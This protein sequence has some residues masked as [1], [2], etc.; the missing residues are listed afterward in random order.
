VDRVPV[1]P[2]SDEGAVAGGYLFGFST[3]QLGHLTSGHIQMFFVAI[4]PLAVC[5]VVLR[6]EDRIPARRFVVLLALALAA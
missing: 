3:H 2:T 1:V 4:V 6:L 5:L